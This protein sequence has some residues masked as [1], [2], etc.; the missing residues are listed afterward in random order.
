MGVEAPPPFVL[1]QPHARAAPRPHGRATQQPH[2]A[3][4]RRDELLRKPR[5]QGSTGAGKARFSIR[6]EPLSDEPQPLQATPA[7]PPGCVT[8]PMPL[9]QRLRMLSQAPPQPRAPAT[10]PQRRR[11]EDDA[12][13]GEA[14]VIMDG[15]DA[16]FEG[17]PG[18]EGPPAAVPVPV[19]ARPA[20]LPVRAPA[21]GS[22]LARMA[23]VLQD[24]KVR[25][26]V[27]ERRVAASVAGGLVQPEALLLTV[28]SSRAE[29][30]VLVVSCRHG[31]SADVTTLLLPSAAAAKLRLEAGREVV[32]HP[33]LARVRV[34]GATAVL[35]SW[36][37]T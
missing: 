9:A 12:D 5:G 19:H 30:E 23:K 35:A 26:A 28:L 3:A 15:G 1:T 2:S 29:G 17:P 32:V 11:R 21:G 18:M 24:D 13:L 34:R 25:R 8:S 37:V 33:P 6:A 36:N 20:V 7:S 10:A 16:D 4:S 14:D 31:S 22:L 27:F